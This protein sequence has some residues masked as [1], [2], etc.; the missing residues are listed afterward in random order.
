[1]PSPKTEPTGAPGDVPEASSLFGR[2][3]GALV[4]DWLLAS[5]ISAGFFSYD[6]LATLGVFAAVT[7]LLLCT[8]GA[9]IG[10]RLFGLRVYRMDTGT[11]PI[12]PLQALIRTVC[13]LLLLPA[14]IASTDGRGLHDVWAGTFIDRFGARATPPRP[15]Q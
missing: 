2:R 4:L 8:L 5:A 3:L 9:T 7:L 1:M 13:L 10:H 11:S 14:A 6:P 15:G 12:A